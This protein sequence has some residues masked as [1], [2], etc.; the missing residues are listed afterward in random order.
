MI[1]H[2]ISSTVRVLKIL[3]IRTRLLEKLGA[4]LA[5]DP[6]ILIIP[7]NQELSSLGHFSCLKI[8]GGQGIHNVEIL[9]CQTSA[10]CLT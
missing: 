2:N 9:L 7:L 5:W 6:P 3:V 8:R 1:S 10:R 4:V